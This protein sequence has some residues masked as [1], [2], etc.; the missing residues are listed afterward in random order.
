MMASAFPVADT[1]SGRGWRRRRP[2]DD[3][4]WG[5]GRSRPIWRRNAPSPRIRF[6][7]G[8]W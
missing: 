3:V 6:R 7:F 8:G 1:D 2:A 4:A 5:V